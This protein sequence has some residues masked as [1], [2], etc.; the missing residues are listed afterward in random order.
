MFNVVDLRDVIRTTLIS[1]LF[2]AQMQRPE[3]VRGAD[4]FFS[5]FSV[6][7]GVVCYQGLIIIMLE[8]SG[9]KSGPNT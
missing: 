9:R 3:V 4:E 1:I 7:K 2:P 5:K 6:P 8:E